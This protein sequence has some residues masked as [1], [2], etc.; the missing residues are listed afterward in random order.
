MILA[1]E[2][3]E[4]LLS[5]GS[6]SEGSAGKAPSDPATVVTATTTKDTPAETIRRAS[7]ADTRSGVTERAADTDAK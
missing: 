4:K 5:S 6:P 3:L 1:S 7:D 2:Q